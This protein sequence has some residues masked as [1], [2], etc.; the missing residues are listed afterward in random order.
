VSS[1]QYLISRESGFPIA[2]D[3]DP[4][5]T[6]PIPVDQFLMEY[7]FLTVPGSDTNVINGV[8]PVEK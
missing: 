4:T 1:A 5:M 3:G 2:E 8:V 6:Q 7:T